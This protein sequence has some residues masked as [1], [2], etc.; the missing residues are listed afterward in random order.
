M[1]RILFISFGCKDYEARIQNNVFFKVII[2]G[3]GLGK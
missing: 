1:N 2:V 3:Y